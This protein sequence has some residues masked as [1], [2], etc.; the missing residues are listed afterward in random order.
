MYIYIYIYTHRE[1]ERD[2]YRERYIYT[3]IERE[4]LCYFLVVLLLLVSCLMLHLLFCFSATRGPV[5][6]AAG[7][8]T[9]KTH[10]VRMCGHMH[11][12]AYEHDFWV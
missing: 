6:T 10:G 8:Y 12:P 7:A 11:L 9:H 4:R 1:R 5:R 3:Y 2:A